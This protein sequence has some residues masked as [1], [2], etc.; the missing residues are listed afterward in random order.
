LCR[1]I[2]SDDRSVDDVGSDRFCVPG[3]AGLE[4]GAG[5]HL[6]AHHSC[7]AIDRLDLHSRHFLEAFCTWCSHSFDGKNVNAHRLD[8]WQL[9]LPFPATLSGELHRLA[10]R[11][12]FVFRG[13]CRH[14]FSYHC[15]KVRAMI[16]A[17]RTSARVGLKSNVCYGV[18]RG[19]SASPHS[20]PQ[21]LRKQTLRRR[22]QGS[23]GAEG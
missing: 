8:G 13:C 5:A 2:L 9:S 1:R 3:L 12:F 22:G 23:L 7:W 14:T 6:C 19:R 21:Y 18:R 16:A 4:A 17:I 20:L 10:H 11:R 15:P